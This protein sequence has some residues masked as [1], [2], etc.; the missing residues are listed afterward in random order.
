MWCIG[1][2]R[3]EF[4]C[5]YMGRV[6]S[7]DCIGGWIMPLQCCET[8]VS[9]AADFEKLCSLL[10]SSPGR[11]ARAARHG[12]LVHVTSGGLNYRCSQS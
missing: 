3:N 5:F 4:E 7:H 2:E 9:V 6:E 1:M 12:G 8:V 10:Y 11:N